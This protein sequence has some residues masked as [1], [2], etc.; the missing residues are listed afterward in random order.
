[1]QRCNS[2]PLVGAVEQSINAQ[3]NRQQGRAELGEKPLQLLS[4]LA[5]RRSMKDALAVAGIALD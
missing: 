1:L 3:F 2:V 5:V 4:V